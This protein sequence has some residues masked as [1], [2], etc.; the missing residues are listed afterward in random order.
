[1]LTFLFRVL[2]VLVASAICFPIGALL[3]IIYVYDGIYTLTEK[4]KEKARQ[5]KAAEEAK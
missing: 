2:V 5:A 4:D 1:M 3:F